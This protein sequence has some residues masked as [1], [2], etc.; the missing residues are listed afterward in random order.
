VWAAQPRREDA[1]VSGELGTAHSVLTG[2][3]AA[4]QARWASTPIPVG[5]RL[6]RPTPLFAKLDPSLGET[7]PSWAPVARE[8]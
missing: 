4:E 7:G 6:E 8:G 1:G 3:Y 2:D 5:R